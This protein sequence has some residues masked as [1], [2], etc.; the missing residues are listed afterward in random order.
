M[1]HR[2]SIL[3]YARK[4]KMTKGKLAPIYVRITVNG[5]RLEH[6]IQRYVEVARWSVAAGRAKGNS[7]ECGSSIPTSTR[8]R[9]RY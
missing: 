1:E 7:V 5:Q 8:L 6:S 3:F 9:Q 2:I 4:S